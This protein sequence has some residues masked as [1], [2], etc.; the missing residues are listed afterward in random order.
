MNLITGA[1]GIVGSHVLFHLLKSGKPVVAG[2]RKGSN[3][4]Q[5]EKLFSYYTADYKQLFEKIKWIDLDIEDIFS[6]EEALEGVDTVYHCAGFVSFYSFDRK[7]IFAVNEQGTRNVVNACLHKK[8]K[9][10]CHVSSIAAI[11]NSDY[12]TVLDESVYWKTS[13]KESD[14]AISK[15]NAEREVWR[16]T[17]EG[18]NAVIVNPGLILTPGFW[19]QSSAKLVSAYYKIGLFY[20]DGV[21][22]YVSADD[23]ARAMIEL[24][25]KQKFN[26][27]YILVEN[28]YEF[29]DIM[30]FIQAQ[31]GRPA[32]KIQ[33]PRFIL[34]LGRY[35][36]SFISIFSGRNPTLTKSLISSAF[37]QQN[38]SNAKIKKELN[39]QF[40]PT[41]EVFAQICKLYLQE[42]LVKK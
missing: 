42:K 12:K 39:F 27:R 25:E 36:E 32:P 11:N 13:G 24:I 15:Y 19:G 33:V 31:F 10:L 17:E 2:K 35:A 4:A 3:L 5:V 16:G 1:T 26:N 8:V 30:A 23:V 38:Y 37:N 18:L 41:K 29:K 22:A 28:N 40:T 21:A 9:A 20:I 34:E 14:Y 7:K 6:I